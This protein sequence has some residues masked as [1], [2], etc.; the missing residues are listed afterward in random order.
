[1]SS[2]AV[3]RAW[4]TRLWGAVPWCLV[5]AAGVSAGLLGCGGGAALLHPAH[6]LPV[7]TVSV[8]AGVSG[9]F[10]SGAI[11][12][13]IDD[14][15]AAASQPLGDPASAQAY[16]EGVLARAL[17][18][19]GAS[20]WVSARAGLAANYEAGLTYTGRS[21][22]LDGRHA[23][24]LSDDWAL[25]FGLGVSGILLRP[26][27]SDPGPM[28]AAGAPSSSQAEFEPSARGFGADVP[29]VFGYRLLEGFGDLWFGPRLG[30]EHL[31]GSLDLDQQAPGSGRLDLSGNHFWGGLLAGFSLGIPPLWLRF[32]LATAYHHLSGDLTP[33]GGAASALDFEGIEASGWTFSPSGAIVGKF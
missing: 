26:E 11:E 28:S 15:R 4:L 20:P 7:D 32:E 10:A 33:R 12:D 5:F 2:G 6:T 17:I 3:A 24:E 19:P 29:L 23:W 27:R 1:M 16:A 13:T 9:Q 21:L 22:R 14:G 18:A 31:N 30:F 25:S 8:G